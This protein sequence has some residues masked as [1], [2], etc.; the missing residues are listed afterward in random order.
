MRVVSLLRFSKPKN[1]GLR[2]ST[3]TKTAIHFRLA[4]QT[5][6]EYSIKP[7]KNLSQ[8]HKRRNPRFSAIPSSFKS[9]GKHF[10]S[11]APVKNHQKISRY[12]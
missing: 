1:R 12:Q 11:V 7:P 5:V 10:A 3:T 4:P 8:L 2:V 6:I 9:T